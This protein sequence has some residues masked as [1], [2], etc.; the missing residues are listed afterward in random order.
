M[1]MDSIPNRMSAEQYRREYDKLVNIYG[2]SSFHMRGKRDQAFAALAHRSG[3]TQ[4]E[5]AAIEG[6][7]R[8]HVQRRLCFGRFLARIE[9]A[10]IGGN[11]ETTGKPLTER[12]FRSCWEATSA[13]ESDVQRF[14]A[15]AEMLRRDATRG[16]DDSKRT[17]KAVG[18]D[19]V[20][21]F[22]DDKWHPLAAMVAG[23]PQHSAD[24]IAVVLNSIRT[25]QT[26]GC[27]L[28]RKK[29]GK[30]F[31]YRIVKQE[32]MIPAKVVI[33]RLGPFIEALETES[34]KHSARFVPQVIAGIAFNLK[35]LCVEMGEGHV[36]VAQPHGVKQK[37]A[38]REDD[39]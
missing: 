28:E 37:R 15:V 33:E 16:P 39:K 13:S 6:V 4:E 25:R 14:D 38:K 31:K 35:K 22:A 7:N 1:I 5:L 3:L 30:V 9:N 17:R 20:A 18:T 19:L 11:L 8:Q 24:D 27:K 32:L 10:P 23:L 2:V 36:G 26:Y 29:T 34:R 21:A 12:R